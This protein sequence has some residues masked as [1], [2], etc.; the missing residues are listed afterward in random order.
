MLPK[1]F[2]LQTYAGWWVRVFIKNFI[3][4]HGDIVV[5]PEE[6][7]KQYHKLNNFRDE[8]FKKTGY[9]PTPAQIQQKIGDCTTFHTIKVR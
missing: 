5:L 7:L 9:A 2:R 6:K 4:K 8:T 3:D 1:V